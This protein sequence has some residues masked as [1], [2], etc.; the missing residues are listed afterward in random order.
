M[1]G[2]KAREAHW[3]QVVKGLVSKLRSL[4]SIRQ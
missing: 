1:V 2:N 4:N 3:G